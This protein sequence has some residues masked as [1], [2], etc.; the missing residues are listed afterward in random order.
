M[1]MATPQTMAITFSS[2]GSER[3]ADPMGYMQ[4]WPANDALQLQTRPT[5][6][7]IPEADKN[8]HV[9]AEVQPPNP[10]LDLHAGRPLAVLGVDA[11]TAVSTEALIFTV[12]R[13]VWDADFRFH[14]AA[15]T[16]GELH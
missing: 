16:D 14:T 9:A 10:R 1:I 2:S 15:C 13:S 11:L 3:P 5:C 12:A 4:R 7:C 8:Q 6:E